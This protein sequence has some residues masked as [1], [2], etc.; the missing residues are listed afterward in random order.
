M[1]DKKKVMVIEDDAQLCMQLGRIIE[2]F[3]YTPVT[4]MDGPEARAKFKAESPDAVITDLYL[5]HVSGLDLLH[6]FHADRP[7]LPVI[8]L[9]GHPSED[10]I[11]ETL[12]EGGYTYVAKP[13]DLNHLRTLI[14]HAL[15]EK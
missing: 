9:T 2:Y 3:G 7:D 13:V 14:Q 6:E 15:G 5:P 8:V 12:L 4:A 1:S 10:S 11:R